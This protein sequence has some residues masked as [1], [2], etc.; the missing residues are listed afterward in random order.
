MEQRVSYRV[1][2]EDTDS[3]G[4]VYYA[5][6]FKFMERGRSEFL[7]GRGKS[8][9]DWNAEG[10]L[11]VVHSVQANF[12]KAA[13]LGDLVDVVT[14]FTVPSVYRGRFS[15]RIE[16]AGELLVEGTVDVV[17]LNRDQ[18]LVEFPAGLRALAG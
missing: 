18:N 16:R 10:F 15:Q 17:C 13:V 2:Y 1:Y 3:L 14:T 12:K 11:I 8:I 7:S 6:Y 4:V 5:N 9:A